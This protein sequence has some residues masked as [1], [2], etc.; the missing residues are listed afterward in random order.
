MTF[1][2]KI[3]TKIKLLG[4]LLILL[5]VSTIAVTLYLNQQ[6]QKDALV[7]N[8]AGKQRMLTQNIAK[9]VFYI[10]H[11]PEKRFDELNA[12]TDEFIKG[13]DTLQHGDELIGTYSAPT[14]EI[15]NK[16][17]KVTVLWEK[18]HRNINNFITMSQSRDVNRDRELGKIIASIEK[19]NSL[20]LSNVD[21]LVTM[22]TEYSESKTNY[23]KLFQYASA[24]VLL[25][26]FVYSL[27]RLKEIETHVDEFMLY[28]KSLAADKDGLKLKPLEIDAESELVEVSDTINCFISKI[29][30]A[31]DYSNQALEKSQQASLKLEELTDE[32]DNI[33]DDLQDKT[34]ISKHLNTSEDIAIESTEGLL[35]STK[36]LKRLRNELDNLILSCQNIK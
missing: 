23:M 27:I 36:K 15:R 24:L 31:V 14:Q 11:H 20:L 1:P 34:L 28:S 8:I 21:E 25:F 30:S 13:L 16:I 9:N 2:N 32:F 4:A 3:S 7:I 6:N 26:I 10:S 17:D 29:N 33:I 5:T 12:A 35:N 18:F 19:E 22:Y